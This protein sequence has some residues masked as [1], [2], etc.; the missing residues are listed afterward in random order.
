MQHP[1]THTRRC[2]DERTTVEPCAHAIERIVGV[3]Q[4]RL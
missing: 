1:P 2:G 4:T 3:K